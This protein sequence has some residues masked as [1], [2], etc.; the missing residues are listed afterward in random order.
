MNRIA[1]TV[2]WSALALLYLGGCS[3]SASAQAKP[4]DSAPAVSGKPTAPVTVSAELAERSAR[5]TVRFDAPARDVRVNVHGV[6]GLEVSGEQALVEGGSYEQGTVATFDVAFT[7]GAG[8]SHLVV[9]VAGSFQ[10]AP[11]TRVASFAVGTPTE[12]QKRASGAQKLESDGERIKVMPAG[13]P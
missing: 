10:G 1:S 2:L 13:E 11:R 7:P 8:R 3:S 9:A 12:A 4:D 6:D 5:V